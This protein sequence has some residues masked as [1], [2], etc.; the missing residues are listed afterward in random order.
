M[1]QMILIP[2]SMLLLMGTFIPLIRNDS[3][4]VVSGSKSGLKVIYPT[5]ISPTSRK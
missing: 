3:E 1:W 2:L 4:K 5:V